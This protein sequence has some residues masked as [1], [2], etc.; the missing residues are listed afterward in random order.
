[1]AS[2]TK[3]ILSWILHWH[4]I[5]MDTG[6]AANSAGLFVNQLGAC[7][8][9]ILLGATT[10]SRIFNIKILKIFALF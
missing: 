7:A 6:G 2:Q 1:M 5:G 9:L 3:L 4:P 8:Q 10:P